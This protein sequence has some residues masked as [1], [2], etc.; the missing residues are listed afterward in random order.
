MASKLTTP[1]HLSIVLGFLA[2][3]IIIWV[4]TLVILSKIRGQQKRA[5]IERDDVN[6][7]SDNWLEPHQSEANPNAQP[8]PT[9]FERR[10]GSDMRLPSVE[11]GTNPWNAEGKFT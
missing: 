4:F 7:Y 8:S 1:L 3:V 11:A 9:I 10:R 5:D 6:P 2:G